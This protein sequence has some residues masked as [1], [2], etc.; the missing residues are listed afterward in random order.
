MNIRYAREDGFTLVELMVAAAVSSIGLVVLMGSV[1][2]VD[3][4][5]SI[6]DYKATGT[7]FT[8]NVLEFVQDQDFTDFADL[9]TYDPGI[10]DAEGNVNIPGFGTASFTMFALIPNGG[11]TALL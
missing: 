6:S 1:L 9:A 10:A 8:S 5:Q 4:H 2:A 3:N 11:G 7:N